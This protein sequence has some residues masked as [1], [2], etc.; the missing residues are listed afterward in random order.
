MGIWC[1]G[2]FYV[3]HKLYHLGGTIIC[4]I[5]ISHT[6]N[7]V[8]SNQICGHKPEKSS[9]DNERESWG[10]LQGR[11][12]WL[13]EEWVNTKVTRWGKRQ[14]KLEKTAQRGTVGRFQTKGWKGFLKFYQ[15]KGCMNKIQTDQQMSYLIVICVVKKEHLLKSIILLSI[16]LREEWCQYFQSF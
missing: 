2:L 15:V 7:L 11:R 3:P 14:Q 13:S 8:S 9:G 5:C 12:A 16:C 4:Q 1:M 10:H 6:H